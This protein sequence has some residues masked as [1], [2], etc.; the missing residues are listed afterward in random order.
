MS[1]KF[2]STISLGPYSPAACGLPY[3][4]DIQQVGE[5]YTFRYNGECSSWLY[6]ART[7][8]KYCASPAIDLPSEIGDAP[9]FEG[10][11]EGPEDMASLIERGEV[12]YTQYCQVCHQADGK[13]SAAFPPLAGS[14]DYYGSAQNHAKIIVHGLN[15]E[16]VVQ[17][18]TYNGAMAPHGHLTDYDIAAVA[19]FERNSWGN[20]DGIVLPTDVAAV[21]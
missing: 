9:E 17:G 16:I 21:R 1:Q 5:R 12:I 15:G 10:M 8:Y 13:G 4:Q 19:T 18:V 11:E 20:E 6:S 7:G 2:V 3:E 14:G